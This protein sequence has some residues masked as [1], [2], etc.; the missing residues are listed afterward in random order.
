MIISK[1]Y[2]CP[3]GDWHPTPK[4]LKWFGKAPYRRALY[5]WPHIGGGWDGWEYAL[6]SGFGA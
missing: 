5:A 6:T 4:W 1:A 2:S 3:C